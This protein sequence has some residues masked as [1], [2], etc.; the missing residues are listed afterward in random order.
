[1]PPGLCN[2]FSTRVY[3]RYRYAMKWLC[4]GRLVVNT[5]RNYLQMHLMFLSNNSHQ[6]HLRAGAYWLVI[7]STVAAHV[8]LVIFPRRLSFC[9]KLSCSKQWSKKHP[10]WKQNDNRREGSNIKQKQ[11]SS[12]ST[13]IYS[14]KITNFSNFW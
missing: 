12:L 2:N 11:T 6:D 4:L 13:K 14:T 5:L 1:M 8:R 3:I 9:Q 10:L 7:I